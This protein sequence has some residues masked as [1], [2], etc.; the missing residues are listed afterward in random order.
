MSWL[1]GIRHVRTKAHHE[2]GRIVT[3]A[4]RRCTAATLVGANSQMPGASS[5]SRCS[6]LRHAA[7]VAAGP[8]VIPAGN[9]VGQPALSVLNGFGPNDL[10]TGIQFTG[11]A[12]SEARLLAVAAAYQR[13]TEW[14][15]KR[16]KL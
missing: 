15:K 13:A 11:R 12:W 10:P 16:P 2:S 6:A 1:A 3:S 4:K 14:H 9:A 8:P 7:S 5:S